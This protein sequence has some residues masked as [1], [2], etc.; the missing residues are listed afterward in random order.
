MI[1]I[2][3][4]Q[5]GHNDQINLENLVANRNLS[6]VFRFETGILKNLNANFL[7]K[8]ELTVLDSELATIQVS[9]EV[10]FNIGIIHR[11]LQQNY[12][13]RPINDKFIVVSTFDFEN[14]E[15]HE[16]ISI[17]NY[18]LRFAYAFSVIHSAYNG[19]RQEA[20]ALMQDNITGCLFDKA[21]YKKQIATFFHNPHI[22][23]ASKNTLNSKTL[24]GQIISNVE[25]EIKG[26]KISWF[27]RYAD[28]MKRHPIGATIIIFLTSFVL[29]EIGGN[30]I[31]DWLKGQLCK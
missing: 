13:S 25:T 17:E 10:S 14:L 28:W 22:S 26:L 16:G 15:L 7:N 9:S 6:N 30:F 3:L 21:I 29:Q 1:T 20:A 8:E 27:Y 11:P 2:K 5:I 23:I 4:I 18:L 12:F 24:D 19:L 31:Y